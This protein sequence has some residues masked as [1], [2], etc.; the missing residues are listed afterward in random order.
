MFFCEI[1]E[2]CLEHIFFTERFRCLLVKI[3]DELNT[4]NRFEVNIWQTGTM[5]IEVGFVIDIT[6]WDDW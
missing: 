2:F 5:L 1:F 4:M 3:I 6:N